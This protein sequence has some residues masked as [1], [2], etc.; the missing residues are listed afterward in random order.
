M[1]ERDLHEF[2]ACTVAAGNK[3]MEEVK[4]AAKVANMV[5]IL[6]LR[7]DEG[8]CR[9]QAF[10]ERHEFL[11]TAITKDG[12]TAWLHLGAWPSCVD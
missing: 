5:G 12:E 3:L 10:Y 6:C 7:R 1:E 8:T 2:K 9:W 4:S 11:P